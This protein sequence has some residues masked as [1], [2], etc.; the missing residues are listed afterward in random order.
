MSNG[1]QCC[2]LEICCNAAQMVDRL[3][4]AI[5]KFSRSGAANDNDDTYC[6]K[7]VAEILVPWMAHE[8]LVFAPASMRTV[9]DDIVAIA[10]RHGVKGAQVKP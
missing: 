7:F 4:K 6:E 10:E 8:E 2:A 5:A 1:A 3:P 9:I